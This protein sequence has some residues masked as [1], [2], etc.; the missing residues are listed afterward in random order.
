MDSYYD[1]M[2][3]GGYDLY[4]YTIPAVIVDGNGD[5]ISAELSCMYADAPD[6]SAVSEEDAALY[7]RADGAGNP[8]DL[9]GR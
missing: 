9:S 4:T 7:R 8:Y 2:D 1:Y 5:E 3:Y 6:I